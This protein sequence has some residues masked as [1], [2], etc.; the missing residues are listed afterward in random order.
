MRGRFITFEGIE[1][2]GKTTQA[3]RLAEYLKSKGIGVETFRE[4]GGVPIAEA[5]REILLKIEYESMTPVTE[6]FLYEA[7]RAQLVDERIRPAL[8]ES[9]WVICDRYADSTLAYQGGGR[10]FDMNTLYGLQSIATR[11]LLPNRTYLLDVPVEEGLERAADVHAR[12][13]IE[14]EA[15]EFHER[16]RGTFKQLA[17]EQPHRIMVIDGRKAIGA[18]FDE[19]RADIDRLAEEQ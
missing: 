8:E 15:V 13:R 11:G 3:G 18:I 19:I 9:K 12:D 17:D 7:A 2:S 5:I 10:G 4:P 14:R 6:L 16:V 1:G